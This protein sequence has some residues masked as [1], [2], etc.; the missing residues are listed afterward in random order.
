MIK[1]LIILSYILMKAFGAV[2]EYL[3]HAHLKG[4]LP[5]NVKDVY[6]EEEYK[7]WMSYEAENGKIS[8]IQNIVQVIVMVLLLA[9]DVY[10]G[11][12]GLFEDA[13]VYIQYLAV[14]MLIGIISTVIAI[15]FSYYDTFVIEE[16]YGMNKSTKKTF[17]LDVIKGYLI[18]SVISFLLIS[19][20]MILFERFGNLAI[21]LGTAV[22]LV[23]MLIVM[24]II[25]PLM[26]IFNKFTP[27]EDGE[28]KD[29]LLKLCEKYDVKVQKI[30]VRDASRR[31]TKSN[32]F[33][34]GYGKHKVI[35]LD[36]NLVKN[37]AEDEILAVFA[38]EF[39]H[40][41]HKHTL[42]TLP[43]SVCSTLIVFIALGIVLNIPA[44][45]TAFG[46]N[47]VNYLFAEMLI[48][49]I[50]WPVSIVIN[51]IGNGLSRK[52]EYQA[53]AFAAKEGYGENLIDALKKLNKEA[54]GDINPHPL[55]VFLDYSH[56]TLSQRITAIRKENI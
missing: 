44:L 41:K 39:G 47:G 18:E 23:I 21:I 17:W 51:A 56:P 25:V 24:L 35:S 53:D 10:A 50:T 29:K 46:F 42:K 4:E 55:K 48:S 2:I 14:I 31:T 40:A 27:L 34:S 26:R 38:H 11:L 16:K 36:D 49:I 15:P 37:F 54:L 13:N 30:L 19:L 52:N 43:F 6:N 7:K 45:Y 33:F 20:L 12:F 8:L 22:I 32:A 3:N 5:S 28:L 1:V 9:L